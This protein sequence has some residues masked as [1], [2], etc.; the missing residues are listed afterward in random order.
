MGRKAPFRMFRVEQ[1]ICDRLEKKKKSEFR[2]D[3]LTNY[4]ESILDRYSRDL[5]VD[6]ALVEGAEVRSVRVRK[7]GEDEHRKTA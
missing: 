7:L 4:I 6:S 3:P 2:R 1:E 5:L